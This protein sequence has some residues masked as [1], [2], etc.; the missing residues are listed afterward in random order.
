MDGNG[1]DARTRPVAVERFL[2]FPSLGSVTRLLVLPAIGLLCAACDGAGPGGPGSETRLEPAW[3]LNAGGG[4]LPEPLL[5]DAERAYFSSAGGVAAIDATTGEV[6]WSAEPSGG[7]VGRLYAVASGFVAIVHG[8]V[9][10]GRDARDGALLWERSGV[11]TGSLI[12]EGDAFFATD[13]EILA[14]YDAATGADR[15]RA[16]IAPGGFIALYASG[17][18][19]CVERQSSPPFY[20]RVQCFD[21]AD[22]A[23][24]WSREVGSNQPW[25]A[26]A[27]NR[28][29]VTAGEAAESEE[30]MGLDAGTG[31]TAW[32]AAGLPVE[33]L[34]V[35]P[36]GA[37]VFGCGAGC[38]GVR[39]ADGAE[40]WRRETPAEAAPP[41]VMTFMLWV[42]ERSGGDLWVLNTATGAVFQRL[43]EPV[44]T[45]P[46]FG[47]C[48]TPA[49]GEFSLYVFGC[50]GSL[51]AYS[52][53]FQPLSD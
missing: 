12:G 46:G 50:G 49:A 39:A 25:V 19:A 9:V 2:P 24:R 18:I 41:T 15:W 42:T 53:L 43:S 10:T 48:G 31:E 11:P 3:T 20:S 14:V 23:E 26:I 34:A 32:R 44:P 5:A 33:G 30:W 40:L 35:A 1:V 37:R 22:G 21:R 45:A 8:D 51:I 27:G 17:G 16:A 6:L 52:L 4:P 38:L 28:V 13:G 36:D 29:V 7:R 47:F